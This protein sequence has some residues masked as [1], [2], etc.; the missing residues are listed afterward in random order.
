MPDLDRSVLMSVKWMGSVY[1]KICEVQKSP[2]NSRIQSPG[3]PIR[4]LCCGQCYVIKAKHGCAYGILSLALNI[5][6]QIDKARLRKVSRS[7]S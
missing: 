2:S 6:F 3:D 1:C 7:P 4:G 5:W